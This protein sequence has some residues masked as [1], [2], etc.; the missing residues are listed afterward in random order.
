MSTPKKKVPAKD[1]PSFLVPKK[2]FSGFS[3]KGVKKPVRA[4]YYGKKAR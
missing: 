4:T 2:G 3:D 1:T